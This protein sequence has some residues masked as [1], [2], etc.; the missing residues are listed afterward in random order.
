MTL[1]DLFDLTF[2]TQCDSPALEWQGRTYTFGELDRR[3]NQMAHAL[4]VRGFAAGDRLCLQLSNSIEFIEIFLA[5]LRLGVIFV[6]V[7]VLY[8]DR[9]IQHIL[10]DADPR[11]FLQDASGI[12][13]VA[14]TMA[15]Q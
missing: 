10:S 8:K 7:N 1:N 13:A 12:S 9:E 3:A 15:D 2:A 6:P 14:R 11:E 4:T 5:C